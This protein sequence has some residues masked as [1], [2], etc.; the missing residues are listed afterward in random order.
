[1]H[2][3]SFPCLGLVPKICVT[4][5]EKN[6]DQTGTGMVHLVLSA[7]SR[8]THKATTV[9]RLLHLPCEHLST[10]IKGI[11]RNFQTSSNSNTNTGPAGAIRNLSSY[12]ND[13]GRVPDILHWNKVVADAWSPMA[14]KNIILPREK[15]HS[16]K[17]EH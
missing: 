3:C 7:C 4:L 17:P 8:T 16:L 2:T 1:M 9:M 11:Y 14:P 15:L 12:N 13:V 5:K 6:K 10:G